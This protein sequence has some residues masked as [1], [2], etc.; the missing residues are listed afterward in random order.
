MKLNSTSWKA[1]PTG[2][3][4]TRAAKAAPLRSARAPGHPPGPDQWV[5]KAGSS[6]SCGPQQRHPANGHAPWHEF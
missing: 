4:P 2:K 5:R 1:E 6:P 3:E